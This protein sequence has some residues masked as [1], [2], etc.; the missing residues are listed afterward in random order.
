MR[1]NGRL[2]LIFGLLLGVGSPA[3]A[4]MILK[5]VDGDWSNPVG[6]DPTFVEYISAVSVAYGNKSEDQIRWGEPGTAAGKSGL[7]FTGS[8]PPE[9]YIHINVPFEVGQLAHFN[10]PVEIGTACTQVDLEV[11]MEF[12]DGSSHTSD[13]RFLIDET[14]NDP[15]PPL[16]DDIITFPSPAAQAPAAPYLELVGF[17][18]DSATLVTHFRSP[19]GTRNSTLLW[20]RLVPEPSTILL[21]GLGT[22]AF[23]RRRSR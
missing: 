16:S 3:Q 4:T 22:L 13:L 11:Y 5:H 19:E 17:G 21:L 10:N 6:G 8:A 7:G 14:E 12:T 2:L 23:L 18:P 15:G 20:A 1:M 9:Q